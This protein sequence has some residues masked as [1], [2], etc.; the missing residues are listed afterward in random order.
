MSDNDSRLDKAW[1]KVRNLMIKVFKDLNHSFDSGMW[2]DGV[3]A[4]TYCCYG[5]AKEELYD[6]DYEQECYFHNIVF[7]TLDSRMEFLKTGTLQ[8]YFICENKNELRDAFS[9][10]GVKVTFVSNRRK[11]TFGIAKLDFTDLFPNVEWAGYTDK[12]FTDVYLGCL[13]MAYCLH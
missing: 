8:L 1:E 4:K 3:L 2:T 11:R 12:F 5:C 6:E 9:N 13:C 7:H 10:H